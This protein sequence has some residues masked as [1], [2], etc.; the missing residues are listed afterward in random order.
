MIKPFKIGFIIGFVLGVAVAF[1]ID[2]AFKDYLGGTWFDA[3]AQDLSKLLGR[4]VKKD[5]MI[6]F[7]TVTTIIMFIGLISGLLGG[8]ASKFVFE[9][10]KSLDS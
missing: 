6:V 10:L 7:I 5:E 8:L 2:F 1:M 9:F 3:V 4:T